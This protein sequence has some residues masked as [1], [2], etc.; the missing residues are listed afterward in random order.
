MNIK[1]LWNSGREHVVKVQYLL[2]ERFTILG[3]LFQSGRIIPIIRCILYNKQYR[4]HKASGFIIPDGFPNQDW[5]LYLVEDLR[6]VSICSIT[7]TGCWVGLL[8]IT[9]KASVP[10]MFIHCHV[11][12]VLSQFSYDSI[13]CIDC[14]KWEADTIAWK[15]DTCC[16]KVWEFV[17]G[18]QAQAQCTS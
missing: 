13:D 10:F 14:M 9:P 5:P 4:G 17:R 16:S 18:S 12:W 15:K 6:H 2:R 11:R 7:C 1:Q 3:L 8:I